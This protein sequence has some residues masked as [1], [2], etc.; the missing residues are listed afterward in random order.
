MFAIEIYE[1]RCIDLCIFKGV[2]TG[3]I[4]IEKPTSMTTKAA[5]VTEVVTST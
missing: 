5:D 4:I 2:Y 1:G 3:K